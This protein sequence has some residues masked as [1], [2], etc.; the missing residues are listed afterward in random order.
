MNYAAIN[1]FI[2]KPWIYRENDCWAVFRKAAKSVFGIQ[3]DEVE[4]PEHPD[5]EHNKELFKNEIGREYW[6]L[7]DTPTGGCAAFFYDKRGNVVHIGLYVDNGDILH[8]NGQPEKGGSTTFDNVKILSRLY[9]KIEY[10][11]YIPN[12]DC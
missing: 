11:E 4:I 7:T 8:C 6:R 3:V 12:N 1:S 5:F 10:Y 2:G 9:G